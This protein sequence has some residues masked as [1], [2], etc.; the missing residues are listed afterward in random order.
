[1]TYDAFDELS[2]PIKAIKVDN[3][4]STKRDPRGT[5]DIGQWMFA[6]FTNLTKCTMMVVAEFRSHQTLEIQ[7]KVVLIMRQ[8]QCR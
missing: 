8:G 3:D 1:M 2:Q 7:K 5:T 6:L 4:Q